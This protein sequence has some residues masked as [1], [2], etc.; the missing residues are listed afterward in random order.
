[1]AHAATV[2]KTGQITLPKWAR[3]VLGVKPGQ[4]VI[5]KKAKNN[6]LTIEREKTA[7]EISEEIRK[8]IPK[9][10]R[11]YY[12]KHYRGLTATETREKW[13]NSPE[14]QEWLEEEVRRSI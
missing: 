3:E 4:V 14:A 9:E 12:M 6:T 1:M 5:F 7:E 2:T 10:A 8:I 11:D 13:M